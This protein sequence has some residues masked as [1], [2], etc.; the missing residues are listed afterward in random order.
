[1]G[2]ESDPLPSYNKLR[3]CSYSVNLSYTTYSFNPQ[4]HLT[5]LG[6]TITPTGSSPEFTSP[7]WKYNIW[8]V[9][10]TFP[11]WLPVA[12]WCTT[13]WDGSPRLPLTPLLRGNPTIRLPRVSPSSP[14]SVALPGGGTPPGPWASTPSTPRAWCLTRVPTVPPP[15][16]SL[17]G[18]TP[19]LPSFPSPSIPF[20]IA[21]NLSTDFGRPPPNLCYC[22]RSSALGM[23]KLL[24]LVL[25]IL[26][27]FVYKWLLLSSFPKK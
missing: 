19:L 10:T 25:W 11:W 23:E 21:S 6:T 3:N 13:R 22:R 17:S 1:M 27:S 9:R 18:P 2:Y 24:T 16:T 12:S 26:C 7:P 5:R 4:V 14:W 8:G 20:H 15:Y